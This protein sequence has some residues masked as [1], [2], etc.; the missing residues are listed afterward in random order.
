MN[1]SQNSSSKHNEKVGVTRGN[2]IHPKSGTKYK[3][4]MIC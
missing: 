4:W 2:G 1:K 3:Y